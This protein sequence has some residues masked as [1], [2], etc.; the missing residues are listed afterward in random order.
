MMSD[1]LYQRQR[2]TTLDGVVGQPDAVETIR[3][4]F[5]GTVP[6]AICLHGPT[7]T[8]KSTMARIIAR[9]LKCPPE[10]RMDY[11]EVNCGVVES[12]LDTVRGIQSSM[13]SAPMTGDCRVWVLDEA[14]V[15]S[16]NKGAQEALLKI[17]EDGPDHAYFILCTSDPSRLLPTIL[18]RCTKIACRP[19][20]DRD[21][22]TILKKAARDEKITPPPGDDLIESI[23]KAAAG[24]ARN[25]LVELEKVIGVSDPEKRMQIVGEVGLQRA[26]FDLVRALM[27]YNGSPSWGDVA[28]VLESV[29]DEDPEGL[30]QM[31]L[32]SARTTLLKHGNKPLG[33]KALKVIDCLRDPLYDRNS[34]RAIL[35][36]ACF[37]V[38]YGK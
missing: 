21:L 37:T 14:Q 23:V 38:V 1:G 12:P 33:V 19:I 11:Q 22:V 32:A 28:T 36:A 7:G 20:P 8:G 24:S 30:R 18:G 3:G 5:K 15:L 34:G 29:K 31:L 2:P 4:L 25:A 27:P 10:N 17:L 13:S 16:R 6:N 35:A 26:A 9:M